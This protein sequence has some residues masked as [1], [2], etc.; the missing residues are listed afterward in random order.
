MSLEF[1]RAHTPPKYLNKEEAQ[2]TDDILQ[3]VDPNMSKTLDNLNAELAKEKEEYFEGKSYV[4]KDEADA[5][6]EESPTKE[7]LDGE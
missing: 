6:K 3:G 5:P 4:E 2:K 1:N 7:E